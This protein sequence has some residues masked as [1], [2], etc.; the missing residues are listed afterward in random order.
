MKLIKKIINKFRKNKK[1]VQFYTE[2][3]K[4][5]EVKEPVKELSEFTNF[6]DKIKKLQELQ[7]NKN[8]GDE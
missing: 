1:E 4:I 8:K 2:K 7:R 6:A 3:D 5:E